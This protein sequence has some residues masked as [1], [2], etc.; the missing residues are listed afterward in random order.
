METAVL[1]IGGPITNKGNNNNKVNNNSKG[2][3]KTLQKR[4]GFAMQE[5]ADLCV[6]NYAP[7]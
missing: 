3:E 1:N 7:G 2:K 4:Y 6:I 5:V